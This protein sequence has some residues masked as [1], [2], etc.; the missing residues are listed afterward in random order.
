MRELIR[1]NDPVVLSLITSLLQE[2]EID[3]AVFD[4][5]MS[6]LEGSIGALSKRLM[7]SQDDY[8]QAKRILTKAGLEEWI[9]DE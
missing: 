8:N 4:Q 6:V 3:S 5:N 1:T 9:K 2:A 7:V